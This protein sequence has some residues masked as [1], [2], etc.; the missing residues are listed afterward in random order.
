MKISVITACFNNEATIGST[1]E[2]VAIQSYQNY[3]H[4]IIDG[5]STDQTLKLIRDFENPRIVCKSE[6]DEGIY[7][8][9]NKGIQHSKGDIIG[10][11]HADDIF[12][13][14]SIL[15]KIAESFTDPQVYAVYGDLVYVQKDSISKVVRYWRSGTYSRSNLGRGWM[16]PHP[17][18]YIR[19]NFYE[20]YGGF[21]KKYS[22]S[23]DYDL[24]LRLLLNKSFTVIYI[25][26][27]MVRM[28]LGGISNRNFINI[29]RKSCEDFKVVRSNSIGGIYTVA[30]KNLLKIKQFCIAD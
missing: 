10:F 30:L 9:L 23:A 17:T 21:N 1:L 3:E 5:E 16:I 24:I 15:K 27:V 7:D 25:P 4:L 26:Q 13:D 12:E 19:R 11:L 6:P 18:L 8:A 20:E 22:I 28:R 14:S 2:S 29:W